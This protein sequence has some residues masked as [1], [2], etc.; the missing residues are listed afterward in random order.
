MQTLMRYGQVLAAL[1]VFG[2]L[3]DSS[4]RAQVDGPKPDPPCTTVDIEIEFPSGSVT[5]PTSGTLNGGKVSLRYEDPAGGPFSWF[6]DLLS[7]LLGNSEGGG[8][9]GGGG[10]GEGG[11]GEGGGQP[12]ADPPSEN[13]PSENPAGG[14]RGRGGDTSNP[15][16]AGRNRAPSATRALL[17]PLTVVEVADASVNERS[18][19]LMIRFRPGRPKVSR[20]AL[21]GT[22]RIDRA[23]ARRL[24][25][26]PGMAIAAGNYKTDGNV[27]RLK[28]TQ[29]EPN[30]RGPRGDVPQRGAATKQG[31]RN[32]DRP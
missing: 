30:R 21:D 22:Y 29:V 13:P 31:R 3:E 15:S 24:N 23:T 1:V 28:L 6:E 26:P 11:G 10:G 16:R 17:A 18:Q 12:N 4:T 14:N 5:G 7:W 32:P 25:L 2:C 19:T 8:G 27:L 20:M 9:G